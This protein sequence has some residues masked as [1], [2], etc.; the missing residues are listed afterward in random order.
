MPGNERIDIVM[1][2][3]TM[4]DVA[5]TADSRLSPGVAQVDRRRVPRYETGEILTRLILARLPREDDWPLPGPS[6]LF[7][8]PGVHGGFQSPPRDQAA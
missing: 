4:R 8:S 5:P 7:D 1:T 2:P 6:E 3:Q